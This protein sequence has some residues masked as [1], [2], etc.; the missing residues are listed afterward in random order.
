M[1][2][3]TKYHWPISEKTKKLWSGQASLRRRRSG[4]G[5]KNRTK[6]ICFPSFEGET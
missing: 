4:N 3:H 5:R 6:T 1:H 2:P